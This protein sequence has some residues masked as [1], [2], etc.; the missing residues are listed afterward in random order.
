[1]INGT[2]VLYISGCRKIVFEVKCLGITRKPPIWS[3]ELS[4]IMCLRNKVM[5][6]GKS[7]KMLKNLCSIEKWVNNYTILKGIKWPH[8]QWGTPTEVKNNQNVPRSCKTYES[9]PT[10][11]ISTQKSQW[12]ITMTTEVKTYLYISI[13]H[14][15]NLIDSQ[16][17]IMSLKSISFFTKIYKQLWQLVISE[18]IR[19]YPP[20]NQFAWK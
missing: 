8:P 5:D 18:V 9:R 19:E 20:K 4:K 14:K 12:P 1:M 11:Q 16:A 15:T 13:Y 3:L 6:N 10:Q 2:V 17:Y 7:T